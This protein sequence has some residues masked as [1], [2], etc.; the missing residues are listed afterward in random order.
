[1]MAQ[2]TPQH[3]P[4]TSD[5]AGGERRLARVIAVGFAA[6]FALALVLWARYGS[7]VFME[8]MA[9]AWAYCF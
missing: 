2:D 5:T 4:H 1:M 8:T 7:A 3:T 6:L 9:T